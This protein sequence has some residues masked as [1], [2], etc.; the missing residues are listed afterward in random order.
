MGIGDLVSFAIAALL[1]LRRSSAAMAARQAKRRQWQ[2]LFDK[3]EVDLK[4]LPTAIA[5]KARQVLAALAQG[6]GYWQ[7]GGKRLNAMRN[8]IRI[9]VTR[10]YRLLCWDDGKSVVPF[11]VVSHEDY[12]P[13]LQDRRRLP[14]AFSRGSDDG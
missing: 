10:R 9:P 11:K 4:G 14:S 7:L 6:T 13:I 2:A 5:S 3:D 8:A 1:K 12:N